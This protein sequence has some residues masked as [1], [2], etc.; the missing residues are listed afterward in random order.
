[1]KKMISLTLIG[2]FLSGCSFLQTHRIDIEQGNVFTQA[3]IN[4]L[5]PGMSQ[6]QVKEIMGSPML[7]NIFSPNRIDYVY[8]F[9]S[10]HKEMQEKRVT[11]LFENG[12]LRQ[13]LQ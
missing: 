6:D 3:D 7:I 5:H 12:R 1:M 13:V 8:T 11:C 2:C 9:Q 4:K 10:G